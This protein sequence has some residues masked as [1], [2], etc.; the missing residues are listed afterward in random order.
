MHQPLN[1]NYP[2]N[3]RHHSNGGME[4]CPLE[5]RVQGSGFRVQ[6]VE[7]EAARTQINYK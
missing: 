4:F 3:N 5:Y 6:G 1:V 7:N 2:E